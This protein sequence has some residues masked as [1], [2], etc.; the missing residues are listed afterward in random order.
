MTFKPTRPLVNERLRTACLSILDGKWL[1]QYNLSDKQ[2][3]M[4]IDSASFEKLSDAHL[5]INLWLKEQFITKE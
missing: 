2:D 3:E 5:A 4:N 1:V